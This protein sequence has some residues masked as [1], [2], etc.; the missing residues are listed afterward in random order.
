MGFKA[1]AQNTSEAF[2]KAAA[3]AL[4]LLVSTL[5]VACDGGD[6]GLSRADV[7]EIVREELADAPAR[8]RVRHQ[9]GRSRGGN[10]CGV[11]WNSPA[12]AVA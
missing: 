6:G 12:G 1:G 2:R 8:A 3:A 7:E 4:F 5:L 9:F 11:G 10:P